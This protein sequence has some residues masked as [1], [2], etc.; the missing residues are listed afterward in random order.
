MT[1]PPSRVQHVRQYCIMSIRATLQLLLWRGRFSEIKAGRKRHSSCMPTSAGRLEAT[2]HR[3]VGRR[4]VQRR[5]VGWAVTSG[6]LGVQPA[7]SDSRQQTPSL[8][9][10]SCK[11][12]AAHTRHSRQDV[13]S[14]SLLPHVSW[15]SPQDCPRS[16][17]SQ[18]TRSSGLGG[19]R[20]R[21]HEMCKHIFRHKMPPGTTCCLR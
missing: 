13:G 20:S 4:A 15:Y 21:S 1:Q 7:D 11:Q 5:P 18:L 14:F 17:R 2:A 3:L 16:R 8:K 6:H 19:T 12:A 10:Y 9:R